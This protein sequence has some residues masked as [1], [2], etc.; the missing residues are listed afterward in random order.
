MAVAG[1]EI[2]SERLRVNWLGKKLGAPAGTGRR[3]MRELASIA[4][5][6]HKG[7][8]LQADPGAVAFY[9]RLGMR[10]EDPGREL[11]HFTFTPKETAAF[12]SG[13]TGPT[14]FGG[15]LSWELA[16]TGASDWLREVKIPGVVDEVSLTTHQALVEALAS[17]LERGESTE[18]LALRVR[19]LDKVFGPVRAERIART[20]VLTANRHGGYQMGKEAGCTEHEWRARIESPRT[21]EWHASAHRQ[22]VPYGQPY[23]VL[24]RKGEPQQLLYPGRPLAGGG[25]GQHHPVPLLG[26]APETGSHGRRDA[27]RSRSTTWPVHRRPRARWRRV[28]GWWSR[29]P[30]PGTR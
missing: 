15:Q 16:V 10:N 26:A 4:A 18:Q 9:E 1:Y 22:R 24:N 19:H 7:I 2:E 8:V 28:S 14:S 13:L 11:P 5:Q 6:D 20:E 21:R 25:T 30:R 3:M 29:E 17:G 23:T 27:G 12:A